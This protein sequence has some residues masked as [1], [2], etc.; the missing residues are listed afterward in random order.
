[1][2]K[3][4]LVRNVNLLL[5]DGSTTFYRAGT[6]EDL[7]DSITNHWWMQANSDNPPAPVMAQMGTPAYA[8]EQQRAAS[9]AALARAAEEQ[10]VE[11]ARDAVREGQVARKR[12]ATPANIGETQPGTTKTDDEAAVAAM[13]AAEA[14]AK[15]KADDEAAAAARNAAGDNGPTKKVIR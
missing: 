4:T 8:A 13:Q 1:M 15:R 6:H 12:A 14:E 9:R 11:A 7:P 2:A 5:E 3:I 10:E